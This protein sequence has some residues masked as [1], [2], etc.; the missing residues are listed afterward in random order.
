MQCSTCSERI[1]DWHSSTEDVTDRR[2]TANR[3]EDS[4]DEGGPGATTAAEEDT[5]LLLSPCSAWAAADADADADATVS[6]EGVATVGAAGSDE[7]P[8]SSSLSEPL[9]LSQ[10]DW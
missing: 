1:A 6:P 8:S 9:G 4:A 7:W 3:V 5:L 10:L 2:R